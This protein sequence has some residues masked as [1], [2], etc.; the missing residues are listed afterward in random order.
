MIDWLTRINWNY[1]RRL[2]HFFQFFVDDTY[3]QD[4]CI[5]TREKNRTYLKLVN[6]I[7]L[8]PFYFFWHSQEVHWI[9]YNFRIA[10]S[11]CIWYR[12]LENIVNIFP[13]NKMLVFILLMLVVVN[14][15]PLHV[16]FF[17]KIGNIQFLVSVRIRKNF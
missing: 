17:K 11:H 3:K 5:S 15:F 1:L 8:I 2:K 13:K 14:L 7:I 16:E 6:R 10:R 12:Q 9:F 4:W